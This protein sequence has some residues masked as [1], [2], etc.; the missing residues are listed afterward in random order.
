MATI[1]NLAVM[2]RADAIPLEAGLLRAIGKVQKFGSDL[3]RSLKS[4]IK[5]VGDLLQS[6]PIVG[7]AFAG[8]FSGAGFFAFIRKGMEDV[9][10]MTKAADRLGVSTQ[11]LAKIQ[12]A[13][14]DAFE[15]VEHGMGHMAR[16]LGEVQIG[17]KEASRAFE[18]LGLDAATL[19]KAGLEQSF[20][21]IAQRISE[22]PTRAERAFAA[23][24][25]FGKGG[26]GML[27]VIERGKAGLD[28]MGKVADEHGFVFNR[29]EG[30]GV[31][32][33][34]KAM[35]GIEK[36]IQGLSIQLAIGLAPIVENIANMFNDWIKGLGGAKGIADAILNVIADILDVIG[37]MIHELK[38]PTGMKGAIGPFTQGLFNSL[39]MGAP[40]GFLLPELQMPVEQ[41]TRLGDIVRNRKDRLVT[42]LTRGEG[43]EETA[44]QMKAT[45]KLLKALQSTA[46]N[47]LNIFDRYTTQVNE[48]NAALAMGTIHAKGFFDGMEQVQEQLDK[49]VRSKA[50]ELFGQTRTPLEQWQSGLAELNTLFQ[51]GA[52]DGD[53]YARSILNLMNTFNKASGL[54]LPKLLDISTPEGAKAANQFIREQRFGPGGESI[55]EQMKRIQEQLLS[56]NKETR[57]KVQQIWN[58]IKGAGGILPANLNGNQMGG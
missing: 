1:A 26:L 32:D 23:F 41:M 20:E 58:L 55:Q 9:K 16:L 14:G 4:H 57:I 40:G 15:A 45:E 22:L 56:E 11:F 6:I 53:L 2:L 42:S 49:S 44:A 43:L 3:D 18:L 28:A 38:D 29:G 35:K 46:F 54:R 5:P 21:R 36:S 13:A 10:E 37:Q 39:R 25:M 12:F 17:S 27:P 19:A 24:Q 50:W 7:T 34:F 52:I 8:L 47:G 30:Q 33:A 51:R 31:L 48:L